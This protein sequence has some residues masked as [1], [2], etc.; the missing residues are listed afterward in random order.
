M[1]DRGQAPQAPACF[2]CDVSGA[3]R[4][5]RAE[6]QRGSRWAPGRPGVPNPRH[7]PAALGGPGR[8]ARPS[9]ALAPIGDRR[10]EGGPARIC[11]V[12]VLRPH[13][14]WVTT[15]LLPLVPFPDLE[16]GAAAASEMWPWG[17]LVGKCGQAVANTDPPGPR[18]T[19]GEAPRPRVLCWGPLCRGQTCCVRWRCSPAAVS[20]KPASF[21]P[22]AADLCPICGP[23]AQAPSGYHR[24]S[25]SRAAALAVGQTGHRPGA[26]ACPV[27][28]GVPLRAGRW[29]GRGSGPPSAPPRLRCVPGP[30]CRE[31]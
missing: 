28:E 31:S 29:S 16:V 2:H 20:P 30:R 21:G 12:S 13:A 14:A 27:S 22:A 24:G 15:L 1:F 19:C 4:C 10:L 7:G 8:G 25:R 9:P 18:A 3:V 11:H 17:R 6:K 26:V 5:S 23:P